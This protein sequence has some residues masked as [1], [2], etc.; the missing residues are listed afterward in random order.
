MLRNG[1][2]FVAFVA[3]AKTQ[4]QEWRTFSKNSSGSGLRLVAPEAVSIVAVVGLSTAKAS[5]VSWTVVLR[6]HNRLI[7]ASTSRSRA[8]RKQLVTR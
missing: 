6:G 3:G 5:T 7:P 2:P 4:D 1:L 8:Y